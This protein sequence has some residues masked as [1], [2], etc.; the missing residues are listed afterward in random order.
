VIAAV[1]IAAAVTVL[2]V[3]SD[4]GS[5]PRTTDVTALDTAGDYPPAPWRAGPVPR[6]AVPAPF[7]EAWDRAG[8]RRRCALLFPLDGGPELPDATPTAGK[9]PEDRGW[10]IFLAGRAGSVEVLGLFDKAARTDKPSTGPSYTR[11]WSD[12]SV[13]KYS[14]DVGG[15]APGN[16]D[17]NTSAYEAV[18]TLPDQACTYRIYDTLGRA[19]LEALFDRLRL[20]APGS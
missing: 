7:T 11:T 8:N 20:M 15:A 14:P 6:A 19:H 9:T 13:A 3:V 4:G 10:D 17:P 1:T 18:L 12:G 16:Y 5:E 2:A